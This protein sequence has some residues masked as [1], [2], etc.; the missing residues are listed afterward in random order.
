M[1]TG[2]VVSYDAAGRIVEVVDAEGGLTTI[3]YDLA[4]RIVQVRSADGTVRTQ[5][6]LK[7]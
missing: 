5:R 3:G 2:G 6:F 1:V 4:G 7:P